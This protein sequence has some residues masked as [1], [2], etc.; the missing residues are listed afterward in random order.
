[1]KAIF[2]FQLPEDQN[3]FDLCRKGPENADAVQEVFGWIRA[4]NKYNDDLTEDQA[5]I[6]ESLKAHLIEFI[7][8][9]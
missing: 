8:L 5:E 7:G 3:Q 9:A 1:M 4:Q 2:E 6:L